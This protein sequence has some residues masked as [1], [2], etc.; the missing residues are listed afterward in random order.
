MSLGPAGS[1]ADD[2]GAP[3]ASGANVTD[4][5]VVGDAGAGSEGGAEALAGAVVGDA[6]AGA[7]VG[8]AGAGAGGP[9]TC[10]AGA[11]GDASAVGDVGAAGGDAG[12]GAM[13]GDAGATVT[14]ASAGVK[15]LWPPTQIDLGPEK[16]I[17][18]RLKLIWNPKSALAADSNCSRAVSGTRNSLWLSNMCT[19]WLLAVGFCNCSSPR[20]D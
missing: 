11:A 10:D 12:A 18:H 3:S 9:D 2:S 13:G 7:V 17:G 19:L 6:V 15:A 14:D 4:G 20:T 8:D 1:A 16:R 5:A